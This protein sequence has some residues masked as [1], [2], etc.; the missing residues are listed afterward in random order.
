MI[1][2]LDQV[3]IGFTRFHGA[4]YDTLILLDADVGFKDTDA[5]LVRVVPRR[6]TALLSV[7]SWAYDLRCSVQGADAVAFADDL[8]VHWY[9]LE[10]MHV[11][12]LKSE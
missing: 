12:T 3:L 7:I 9:V 4:A 10:L 1:L 8:R 5:N 2:L 6:H 11:R